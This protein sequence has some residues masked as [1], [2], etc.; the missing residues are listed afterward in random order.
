MWVMD[1]HVLMKVKVKDV[2]MRA[3]VKDVSLKIE[4]KDHH[5]MYQ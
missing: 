5:P 2:L 4:I 1:N 3:K